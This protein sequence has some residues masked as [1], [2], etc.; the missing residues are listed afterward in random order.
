MNRRKRF[1]I[2]VGTRGS[3]L[4]RWQADEV[5]RL[6]A[7]Q[8]TR[9]ITSIDIRCITTAGDERG[10]AP[11]G[12]G[13]FTRDIE[14]L[15]LAGEIDL[16]VHSLKDL[17]TASPDGLQICAYLRRSFAGD[18]LIVHPDWHRSEHA[19]GLGPGCLVGT[20]SPRRRALLSA[21]APQARGTDLRGNVPT[22]LHRCADGSIGAIILAKAGIERLKSTIASVLAGLF[23]YELD[24]VIWSP[25]PAQGV[26]AVQARSEDDSILTMLAA[27]DDSETRLAVTLE[28]NALAASG[29]GCRTAF[30]AF[31]RSAP[32]R[33]ADRSWRLSVGMNHEPRGWVGGTVTGSYQELEEFRPDPVQLKPLSF[34]GVESLSRWNDTS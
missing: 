20:T 11:P 1:R 17:P 15:L 34:D 31:A 5:A 16:A 13:L 30:G 32:A 26:I 3:D 27:L 8:E 14:R 24:P 6:L 22:R 2:V 4:A 19:L 7:A 18:V 9:S 28:R 33:G 12:D 25:A 23:I 21:I 29:G 10:L